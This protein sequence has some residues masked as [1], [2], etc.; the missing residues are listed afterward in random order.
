MI[1]SLIINVQE[2]GT[3]QVSGTETFP[4]L[5]TP[6]STC[7]S[8]LLACRTSGPC[9][10]LERQTLWT[11]PSFIQHRRHRQGRRH[12]SVLPG[13]PFLL[14]RSLRQKFLH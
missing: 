9:G 2:E 13:G 3:K 14:F 11:P 5:D 12:Q 7:F 10:P 8:V 1:S 4:G 6:E